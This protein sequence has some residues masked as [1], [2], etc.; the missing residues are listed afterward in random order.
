MDVLDM[1]IAQLSVAGE[2]HSRL[3]SFKT[4]GHDA[5]QQAL[6]DYACDR[7]NLPWIIFRAAH[8]A[9]HVAALPARARALFA[10]LARTVDASR[11]YAA[12][13]ARRELL[14][15]R[16]LQS[17]RTFYRSLDDLESAGLIT[18]PP[19]TRYGAAG[20]FGRAYLHLTSRAA[21]L[22]GLVEPAETK[23]EVAAT[24]ATTDRKQTN[25]DASAVSLAP[26]CVTVADG[27]IYKD[28]YPTD[29]KRQSGRLPADLQRLRILGFRD[30][31]IFKLMREAGQHAK[32]LSDVVESCWNHLRRATHPISYLRT[33]LRAPVDFAFR[34]RTLRASI[35]DDAV[36]QER[37]SDARKAAGELAGKRFVSR[38]R[39]RTYHVASDAQSVTIQLRDEA[40][41]RVHAGHWIADFVDALKSGRIRPL[42]QDEPAEL[43]R[44]RTTTHFEG[45]LDDLKRFLKTKQ[46]S[47]APA[48]KPSRAQPAAYDAKAVHPMAALLASANLAKRLQNG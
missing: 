32:R 28:Q 10:A 48:D 30:F 22:L 11:P 37:A 7:S 31:L 34:V 25:L 16:A 15:G 36:R 39:S 19:Q 5:D 38:D 8:R 40:A 18:R 6:D 35:A 41:P 42:V 3:N 4:P 44:L 12:I 17:M 20:L 47:T 21:V 1:H 45:R 46:A 26:P 29:Q 9:S 27:A 43:P 14:T 13:F 2:E 24:H 33:L 23:A